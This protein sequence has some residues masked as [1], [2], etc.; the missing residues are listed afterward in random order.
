LANTHKFLE[1]ITEDINSFRIRKIKWAIN[2][3]I[4]NGL[5]LTPYKIQRYA[6][7]DGN[8]EDVRRLVIEILDNTE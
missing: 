3:M 4:Q 7:F 6:G 5:P 1:E 8:S 2:E